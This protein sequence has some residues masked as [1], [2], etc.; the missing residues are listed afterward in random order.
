MTDTPPHTTPWQTLRLTR[1]LAAEARESDASQA[2]ML[3]WMEAELFD[4]GALAV[5]VLDAEDHPLNEP[6]P[7]E[8]PLWPHVIVEALFAADQSMDQALIALHHAGVIRADEHIELDTLADQVWAR[9]WMDDFKPM[10]FGERL[11]VCPT[12]T[13]PDPDWP[14]VVQ[15]DPGLAF[16]TGTHPT[17]ALCLRWLDQ[18]ALHASP[19]SDR[20]TVIDFG[21]GSGILA[22]AAAKLG[23]QRVWATDHDDQA[24][25]ATQDNAE[26]NG[27]AASIETLRPDALIGHTPIPKV[28][29]VLANILAQ[30]L[31]ELAPRLIDLVKPGGQLVLSGILTTQTAAVK[32][33]YASLDG[34]PQETADGDWVCLAFAHQTGCHYN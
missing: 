13:P 28:D 33:A 29:V 8:Q 23:A 6:L 2:A 19:A 22:V 16:G 34:Q 30:P 3:E 11:W 18:W 25:K 14:V 4:A 10:V 7:G 17:T 9:A 15:L 27:V 1:K 31:I 12:H 24:L 26:A 32:A 21:C 20:P 5:T